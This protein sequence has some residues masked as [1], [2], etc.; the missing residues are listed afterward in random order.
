MKNIQAIVLA[1]GKGTR[2][3]NGNPSP[4]PK[5]L[6]ELK[7][8]PIVEYIILTLVKI[9]IDKPILVIGYKGEMI[10]EYFEDRCEYAEQIEQN[11]TGS[12]AKA[13]VEQLGN[14]IKSFLVLQ[15]D[16]S[17]FYK[18]ETLEKLLKTQQESGVKIVLMTVKVDSKDYG[19]IIK[20]EADEVTE[21]REKEFM[22]DGMYQKYHLGN[23]GGYCFDAKWAKE[24]FPKLKLN[25]LGRYD[26]TD[27]IEL[28]VKQGYKV[29]DLEIDNNEWV[30]VNTPE[31]YEVAKKMI[32]EL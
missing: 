10:K 11:G 19:R 2:L 6:F 17:A 30:G 15:C 24:N 7:N 16:D 4:I 26:I 29:L 20:N 25:K 18:P 12:A 3:N 32:N 9:G 14:D 23:C 8:K 5:A 22:T 27:M 21:I 28:A 13:G 1:A 31:Q